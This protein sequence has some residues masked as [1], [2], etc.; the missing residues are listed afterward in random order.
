MTNAVIERYG[1]LAYQ[2]CDVMLPLEV[3]KSSAGYYLGTFD[4]GLN[5]GPC[6]RESEEYFDNEVDAQ[7]ALDTDQW[8]QRDQPWN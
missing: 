4:R 6:S 7:L 1:K 2:Y 3:L 5:E 8:T